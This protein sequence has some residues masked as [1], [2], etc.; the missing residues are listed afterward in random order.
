MQ[1]RSTQQLDA[2]DASFNDD[3]ER[4]CAYVVLQRMA[5][6][7][8]MLVLAAVNALCCLPSVYAADQVVLRFVENPR[9]NE[10]V[11]RLRDLV[12]VLAGNSPSLEQIMQLPLGPSP[13]E[14]SMQTWH[15]RDVL[16]HLELRGLQPS[17]VRWSG[18]T[19][20]ELQRIGEG[21][22]AVNATFEPAFVQARTV[23][24]AE[25][26]VAQAIAEFLELQTGERTDWRIAANVPAKLADV[27]RIRRNIVGIGGGQEPW[28][29]EQEFV[30][31]IRDHGRI[32]NVSIAAHI[33]LPPMVLV[34]KR[35]LGREQIIQADM[36]E[37]A[38]LPHRDGEDPANFYTDMEKLIGKQLKRSISTGLPISSAYVGAPTVIGRNEM[39]E[40]ESVSGGVSV[41]T[42]A[43][44]LGSGAVG[45]LI[46]IETVP[47]KHRMLA[48]VM[49]P[50]KV[51][52]AAVSARGGLER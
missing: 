16:Q 44:S 47:S 18:V 28:L 12:E 30:L 3:A 34:A 14:N 21:P 46:D 38:P 32:V 19:Q 25:K 35:P 24:L 51:R 1:T 49:G 9:T 45:D 39:V 10:H 17:S 6:I 8:L 27:L 4:Y 52:V 42:M 13:R 37:L 48:T 33:D 43:R 15:S 5:L 36:L 23:E 26:L 41:R 29:G 20:V 31:Q 22:E 2:R 40:V 7:M 50:L 11:V